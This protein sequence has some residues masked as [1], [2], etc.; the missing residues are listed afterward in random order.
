MRGAAAMVNLIGTSPEGPTRYGGLAEVLAMP[1][2]HLH[3][4]GKRRCRPGRKMGH[5]TAVGADRRECVDR[6]QSASAAMRI[7]GEEEES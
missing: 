1:G 3:L 4:Y 2:V 6:A 7:H 5:L